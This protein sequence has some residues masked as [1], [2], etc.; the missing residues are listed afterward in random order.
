M[1]L[2]KELQELISKLKGP[3]PPELT[4]VEKLDQVAGNTLG[5][6]PHFTRVTSTKP[7]EPVEELRGVHI[8]YP[9]N[10]YQRTVRTSL[11]P[12]EPKPTCP[13]HKGILLPCNLCSRFPH[14]TRPTHCPDPARRQY[15]RIFGQ[16]IGKCSWFWLPVSW[17][18]VVR[19][20]SGWLSTIPVYVLLD[21]LSP[22][23]NRIVPISSHIHSYQNAHQYLGM[24]WTGKT[25]EALWWH[26]LALQEHTR[27][28][29]AEY[30]A[31]MI[32]A[33]VNLAWERGGPEDF[34]RASLQ[35]GYSL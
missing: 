21:I 28:R 26:A 9:E 30:Q 17:D 18:Q 5:Y 24:P 34:P 4:G 12:P 23:M 29:Q 3:M 15:I 16:S 27:G 35:Y 22:D 11:A 25:Q 20:H 33:V 8:P 1:E 6:N 14:G 32:R 2:S 7:S 31:A 13:V 10:G 19:E